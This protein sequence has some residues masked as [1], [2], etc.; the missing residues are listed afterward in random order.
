VLQAKEHT[1]TPYP[2]IVFT[3]GFEIES[4]KEFRGAS[5]GIK[6]LIELNPP[7]GTFDGTKED[8]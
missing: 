2:F 4:I 6:A 8:P 1:P 7:V 5:H 3:F